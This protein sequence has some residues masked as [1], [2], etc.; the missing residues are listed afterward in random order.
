MVNGHCLP[1]CN[2]PAV[3]LKNGAC[4]VIDKPVGPIIDL[5]P[6]NPLLIPQIKP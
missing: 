6:I 5:K 2:P 4:V 3:R 1:K